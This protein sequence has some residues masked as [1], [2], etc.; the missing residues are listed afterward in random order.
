[1]IKAILCIIIAL[2]M[3]SAPCVTTAKNPDHESSA[4]AQ[5]NKPG[6]FDY[7]VLS[8]SCPP[9]Y[10]RGHASQ[11]PQQCTSSKRLGFVLHGVWPQ[12]EHGYPQNYSNAALPESVKHD[13][14]DL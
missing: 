11:P 7:Y 12:Y 14:A 1:V 2:L 3:L 9:D 10:C 13:F 4:Q 6:V 5:Q 8:L